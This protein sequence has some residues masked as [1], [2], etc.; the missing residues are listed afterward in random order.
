MFASIYPINADNFTELKNAIEKLSINDS[1]FIYT[2]QN[3]NVF[4]FG[5]KCGFLGVLH[6][7]IVQERLE[8]EYNLKIIITPPSVVFEIKYKNE[9]TEYINNPNEISDISQIKEMK[10]P[11]ALVRIIT[12]IKYLGKVTEL[13]NNSRGKVKEINNKYTDTI[14]EYEIPLNE[15][16]FNFFKNLQ[17]ITSGFCSFDY[18]FLEYRKSNLTTLAIIINNKKIDTLEFII[19][20]DHAHKIAKNII[21]K[22][23][24]V[25]QKQLFDI[26]IQAV[27]GKKIIAKTSIKALKKNVLAKCYGGDISRKK[28]LIKK[29]KEGKKR[30]KKIGNIDIPQNAFLSIMNINKNN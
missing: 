7:E 16:L 26:K 2:I 21:E 24:K 19:H 18:E 15:I 1:S 30:L 4:G 27:V 3:S 13:C 25:I 20:K 14:I 12:Q 11:I 6:M 10:E 29:Q 9:K 8:R 22:M 28:K 23:E 17:N 5:F